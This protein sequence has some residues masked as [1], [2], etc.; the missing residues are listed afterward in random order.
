[1][2]PLGALAAAVLWF[3]ALP[4]LPSGVG[5]SGG[6]AARS[7]TLATLELALSALPVGGSAAL[8]ALPA[9][10]LGGLSLVRPPPI[11]GVR[12]AALPTRSPGGPSRRGALVPTARRLFSRPAPRLPRLLLGSVLTSPLFP[13]SLTLSRERA[14][15]L[16]LSLRPLLGRVSHVPPTAP[17][18]VLVSVPPSF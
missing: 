17:R 9:T 11:G 18:A 5:L 13:G 12:I 1:M 7:A 6:P 2:P 4:S 16:G 15:V 3:A 8:V 14:F 10:L